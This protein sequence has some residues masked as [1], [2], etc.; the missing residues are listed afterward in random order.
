[1]VSLGQT[2]KQFTQ[3]IKKIGLRWEQCMQVEGTGKAITNGSKFILRLKDYPSTNDDYSYLQHE[4][5]HIVAFIMEKITMP[6]TDESSEA[7]AYLI[8]YLTKK[9][10]D[11]L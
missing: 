5:F 8:Q 7:Y 11:K 3:S 10:Y 1:M 2:D 6:L 4:I 9:I